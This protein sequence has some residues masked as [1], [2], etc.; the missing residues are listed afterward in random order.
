MSALTFIF[1]Y[2]GAQCGSLLPLLASSNSSSSILLTY[3][4]YLLL[5]LYQTKPFFRSVHLLLSK[6]GSVVFLV[7]VS[8]HVRSSTLISS[9]WSAKPILLFRSSLDS[10]HLTIWRGNDQV[11]IPTVLVIL[12]LIRVVLSID[13]IPLG[14]ILKTSRP[15][16]WLRWIRSPAMIVIWLHRLFPVWCNLL[17]WLESR[18]VWCAGMEIR[19]WLL[20]LWELISRWL[21]HDIASGH[22]WRN[23][24]ESAAHHLLLLLGLDWLVHR[25]RLDVMWRHVA[26]GWFLLGILPSFTHIWLYWYS[27]IFL[28]IAHFD[29]FVLFWSIR[30]ANVSSLEIRVVQIVHQILRVHV[31]IEAL[32]H[33]LLFWWCWFE[34]HIL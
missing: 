11:L 29:Q 27:L 2:S 6:P 16:L 19:V 17:D 12:I 20:K 21:E 13:Q 18:K 10:S 3:C 26:I 7:E 28:L 1:H 5:F 34:P 14:P 30:V 22:W 15:G 33:R 25:E 31:V 24:I 8:V 9:G 4:S 23:S 32:G